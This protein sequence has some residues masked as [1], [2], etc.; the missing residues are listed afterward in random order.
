MRK[1]GPTKHTK[2]IL[3][4]KYQ[5]LPRAYETLNPALALLT[6]FKIKLNR[7]VKTFFLVVVVVGVKF[8]SHR[9]PFRLATALHSI[10]H[11][12]YQ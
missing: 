1:K 3:L 8:F 5:E 4:R 7:G 6:H 12:D 9:P 2:K 10:K 11:T